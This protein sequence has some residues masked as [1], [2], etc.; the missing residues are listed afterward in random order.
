VYLGILTRFLWMTSFFSKFKKLCVM[1]FF[2]ATSRDEVLTA[3]QPLFAFLWLSA[4]R[5]FFDDLNGVVV[6]NADC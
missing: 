3:L 6:S 5:G 2:L 4:T 1:C